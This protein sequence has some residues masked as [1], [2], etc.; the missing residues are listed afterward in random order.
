MI[1]IPFFESRVVNL[2][3]GRFSD[4]IELESGIRVKF[5]CDITHTA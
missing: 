3:R 5:R 4:T 2:I 1:Y